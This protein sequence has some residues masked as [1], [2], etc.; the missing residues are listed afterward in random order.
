MTSSGCGPIP[1]RMPNT[2]WTNSGGLTRPRSRKWLEIVEMGG[3]VALE[4]EARPRAAK[5]AQHE[6]DVLIG[7]AEHEIARVLERLL[8]PVVLESLEAVKH[9]EQ[10][11]I[12]RAHVERRHFRPERLSRLHALLDRHEGRATSGQIHHRLGRLLDARQKARESLGR[13]IGPAGL[14]IACVQVDDRRAGFGRADR[15]LG[16][17][18]RGDGEVRR[19]RRRVDRPRHS[20]GDDDLVRLSHAKRLS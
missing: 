14:L 13:L 1:P 6:F 3:V 4:L 20:A 12:H 7:I 19:H 17:L 5:G 15:R 16:D 11:E 8:L 9:R 10:P 2:V 18:I